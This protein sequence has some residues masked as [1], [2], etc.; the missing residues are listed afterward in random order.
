MTT[1]MYA[2][3]LV[4]TIGMALGR[5]ITEQSRRTL[6]SEQKLAVLEMLAPIRKYALVYLVLFVLLIYRRPLSWLIWGFAVTIVAG[7]TVKWVRIRRVQVPVEYLKGNTLET[8]IAISGT[9]AFVLLAFLMP[10]G[11]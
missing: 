7:Y 5:L 11:A 1:N 10:P 8:C 6:S 3:F 2:A 4:I 9:I